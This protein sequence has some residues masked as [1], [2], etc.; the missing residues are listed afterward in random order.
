M[1]S[2]VILFTRGGVHYAR[3][4]S[5]WKKMKVLDIPFTK[6]L[7]LPSNIKLLLIWLGK[8]KCR[9]RLMLLYTM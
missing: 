2:R 5:L 4:E 8:Y 9:R 3:K 1:Q 6:Q 7:F